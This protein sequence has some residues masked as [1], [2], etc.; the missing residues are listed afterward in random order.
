MGTLAHLGK[1]TTPTRSH[2]G[3]SVVYVHPTVTCKPSRLL[4]LQLATGTLA[5]QTRDGRAVLL[6]RDT[7]FGGMH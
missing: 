1:P 4:R 3:E 6:K 2:K 7:F 5:V